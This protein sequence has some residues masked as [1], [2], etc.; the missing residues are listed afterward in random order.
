MKIIGIA[1]SLLV[2]LAIPA[3]AQQSPG[4]SFTILDLQGRVQDLQY[5]VIDLAGKTTDLQVKETKTEI[6]IEIPADVL[7]D[8]DKA[9][10][11]PKAADALK[12][13]AGIIRANPSGDVR[14]DG[15]TDSKGTDARNQKLSEQRALAVRNWL[16]AKEGI[17]TIKFTTQGYGAK[18]PVSPNLKPNGADDPDGRQKNRRVEITIG[19]R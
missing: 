3:L 9:D 5:T 4:V 6:H 2:A 19:K 14:I 11:R 15:H 1:A 18:R 7:F 13:A 10:I 16:V 8:F 12:Q 17:T